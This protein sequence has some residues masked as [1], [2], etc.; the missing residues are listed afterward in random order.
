ML[1]F[2]Q[3]LR[4]PT[5]QAACHQNSQLSGCSAAARRSWVWICWV[6]WSVI[7]QVIIFVV[8]HEAIIA[9][10]W[11]REVTLAV[12]LLS[13]RLWALAL[14]EIVVLLVGRLL[15]VMMTDGAA[16]HASQSLITIAHAYSCPSCV[17]QTWWSLVVEHTGAGH[18]QDGA[19][20][21]SRLG[22][23][24]IL[25][26]FLVLL[27]RVHGRATRVVMTVAR[28][29]VNRRWEHNRLR[30]ILLSLMLLLL[31]DGR[32]AAFSLGSISSLLSH[33]HV[34]R[35]MS[36][37][38]HALLW[39][40]HLVLDLRLGI[41]LLGLIVFIRLSHVLGSSIGSYFEIC[42]A[43]VCPPT[44]DVADLHSSDQ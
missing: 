37:L 38:R 30:E 39:V 34:R 44:V 7:E 29:V 26:Q 24:R 21:A 28:P 12:R 16:M 13:V 31:G 33:H 36:V 6:K 5:K 43:H 23:P 18:V 42:S 22:R 20:H 1:S 9:A 27:V 40:L 11:L 4:I 19:R 25:G 10:G 3:I 8:R 32:V 17:L 41:L 15:V 2:L 14:M 35:L